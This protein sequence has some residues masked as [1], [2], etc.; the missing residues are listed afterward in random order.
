MLRTDD[1]KEAKMLISYHLHLV[2]KEEKKEGRSKR[3]K[4]IRRREEKKG[5]REGGSSKEE[6]K[7]LT[8]NM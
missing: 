8:C 6:G 3:E 2:S 7:K 4:G 5:R 1:R